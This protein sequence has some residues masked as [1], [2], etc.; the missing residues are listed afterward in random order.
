[1]TTTKRQDDETMAG[2]RPPSA[3]LW[4]LVAVCAGATTPR[5]RYANAPGGLGNKMWRGGWRGWGFNVF[6]R[7]G[8]ESAWGIL[9]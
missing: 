1:M 3:A 7:W 6:G 2:L 9:L 8:G 5:R 4:A